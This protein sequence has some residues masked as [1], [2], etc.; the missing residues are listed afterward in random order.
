MSADNDLMNMLTEYISVLELD[1][2]LLL[3]QKDI[4]RVII[5]TVIEQNESSISEYYW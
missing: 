5:D 3:C 1:I 4:L 2:S